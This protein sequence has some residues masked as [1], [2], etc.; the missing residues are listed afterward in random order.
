MAT[1]DY[2]KLTR[3]NEILRS[4]GMDDVTALGDTRE[5]QMAEDTLDQIDREV[6]AR[7]WH[8]N[9]EREVSIAPNG[10]NK[11]DVPTDALRIDPE[12]QT[13]NFIQVGLE[14]FDVANNTLTITETLDYKIVRYR[15]FTDL[16]PYAQDYIA[17]R[18]ARIFQD[19]MVGSSDAARRL[20]DDENR[21]LAQLVQAE[22]DTS[23]ANAL[24]HSFSVWRA[25]GAPRRNPLLYP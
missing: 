1:V 2:T 16:P 15:D 23:D 11:I 3:V 12:D 17:A 14:M 4:S 6:Q 18:S 8:F 21:A 10:S 7:G 20:R 19:R 22:A 24:R 25:T 9:T 13:K 5:A